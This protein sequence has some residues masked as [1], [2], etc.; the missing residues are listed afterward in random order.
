MFERRN[1][2]IQ[3]FEPHL[4]DF[5]RELVRKEYRNILRKIVEARGIFKEKFKLIE[6][7]SY[8]NQSVDLLS[9]KIWE[10]F[11]KCLED[12]LHEIVSSLLNELTDRL[13]RKISRIPDSNLIARSVRI[14]S[15]VMGSY[16]LKLTFLE[17]LSP[18]IRTLSYI[19]KEM[20]QRSGDREL[21][22]SIW[23]L[24]YIFSFAFVQMFGKYITRHEKGEVLRIIKN[25]FV[26][27]LAIV[28][29]SI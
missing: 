3:A 20:M 29:G 11:R 9:L 13:A 27:N 17:R 12:K 25:T 23:V 14:Y 21:S 7:D 22:G 24:L 26:R 19:E 18:N 1:R 15:S 5:A 4:T 2:I 28:A 6:R 16:Q 10:E 8:T